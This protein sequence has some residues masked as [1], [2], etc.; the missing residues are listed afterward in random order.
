LIWKC[1]PL[2]FEGKVVHRRVMSNKEGFF[3][4]GGMMREEYK[5]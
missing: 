3:G 2:R 4:D 5:K 1:K